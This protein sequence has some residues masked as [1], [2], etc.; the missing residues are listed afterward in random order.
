M[1]KISTILGLLM[2][3]AVAFSSCGGDD[4]PEAVVKS[5]EKTH[6]YSIPVQGIEN[7]AQKVTMAIDLKTA[8]G[9]EIA[10]NLIA[11][12][13]QRGK[14][15]INVRGLKA[16]S[17]TAKIKD[18]KIKVGNRQE[19]SLG[20]CTAQPN[21]NEFNSDQVLSDDKYTEICKQI[22]EDLRSSKKIDIVLTFTSDI[23]LT[24]S[25]SPVYFD[26]TV[27]GLYKYNTYPK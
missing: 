18:M 14:S 17:E 9:E 13:F 8:V 27:S 3:V 6:T 22:L 10:N 24:T 12:D 7:Q 19:I 1:K 11:A 2:L 23:T 16:I 15:S 5:D 26:L 21:A 4:G 20:T 25:G